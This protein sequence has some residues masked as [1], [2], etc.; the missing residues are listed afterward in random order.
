VCTSGQSVS[1][2][3]MS[4]WDDVELLDRDPGFPLVGCLVE[5]FLVG[6]ENRAVM[7]FQLS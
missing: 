1:N 7:G 5:V 2:C 4:W 3:W 6:I